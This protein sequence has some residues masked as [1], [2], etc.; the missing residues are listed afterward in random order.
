MPLASVEK[1]FIGCLLDESNSHNGFL[2]S[3]MPLKSINQE[4]QLS[5]YR[6]NRDGA[7]QKVLAQIYPACFNI[8]GD[9]YFNQLC[10][11]YYFEYPSTNSN[12]NIYGEYFPVFM[13]QQLEINKELKGMEYLGDLACLEW[14]YHCAYYAKNDETFSFEKLSKVDV[15]NQPNICFEI[16]CSLSI[17]STIF[18]LLD[19]W[20]A[21][22]VLTDEKQIFSFPDEDINFCVS[23]FECVPIVTL[24]N[25]QQYVLLTEIINGR[26]FYELIELIQEKH[27][28][29][30]MFE[31]ELKYFVQKKWLTGFVLKSH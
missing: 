1:T 18:P 2:S 13:R 27:I 15:H 21:N 29:A 26:S 20:N 24:L 9:D 17:A 31:K 19:I 10:R 16:S 22:K 23:R 25:Q 14:H 6:G 12:L 28:S 30:E 8:L 5:I 11:R 4:M 3:L 7:Y